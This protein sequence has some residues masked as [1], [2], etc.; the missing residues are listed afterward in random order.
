VKGRA[1][2]VV[3]RPAQV[4]GGGGGPSDDRILQRARRG[5]QLPTGRGGGCVSCVDVVRKG[6]WIRFIKR[7]FSLARLARSDQI[8]GRG[9][10]RF[11]G[12]IRFYRFVVGHTRAPKVKRT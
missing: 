4:A 12:R 9:D 7:R 2:T 1:G 5:V 3:V 11:S 6:R 10:S 8:V